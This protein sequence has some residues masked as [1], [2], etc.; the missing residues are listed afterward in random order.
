MRFF[1]GILN[2]K[3]KYKLALMVILPLMGLLYF[4]G[5]QLLEKYR[6]MDE[7]E[8]IQQLSRLAVKSSALVH[9]LQK[10][11]GATAGFL[12]SRGS[13][14]GQELKVQRENSNIR[15]QEFRVYLGS[16]DI[17]E[18]KLSDEFRQT[19]VMATEN[20]EQLDN[21]RQK[22]SALNIVPKDAIAYY[23]GINGLLLKSITFM[24]KLGERSDITVQSLA[25][26]NF[27]QGKERAGIERAVLSNTF[28]ADQFGPGMYKKFISLMSKQDAYADMYISL[29]TSSQRELY[30]NKMQGHAVEEV[31]RMRKIA[32]KNAT[33]GQF[34]IEPVYWFKTKTTRINLLKDVED[35]IAAE[36]EASAT[37]LSREAKSSLVESSTVALV[38][39]VV[40]IMIALMMLRSVLGQVNVLHDTM[41]DIE[42]NSDLTLRVDV[43]SSDEIGEM[44]ATFNLMM[45]KFRDIIHQVAGSI[46]QLTTSAEEMMA[47]TKQTDQGVNEQR[48]ETDQVA[49]AMTEMAATVQQVAQGAT[50]AAQAAQDADQEA[51]SGRQVVT[52]SMDSINILAQEVQN[53]ADVIQKLAADSEQIG[54]VLDVIKGIADQTNLLALNAAIEAA[55]AGE[56][57]RGFAVVADEVRTLAQRT[58]ESAGEIEGMIERLQSGAE[59]AVTVMENGRTQAVVS[60]EQAEKAVASL[61]AITKAVISIN[62][63]NTQI[64]SA[65]EQQTAVADEINGNIHNISQVAE[66]TSMST[67]E[68]KATGEHL[69]DLAVKL[70][71]TVDQFKV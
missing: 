50:S 70:R 26:V 71:A 17:S 53:A 1:Q 69:A 13:K 56:Q 9:E 12:G 49:T 6:Q 18:L 45:D 34:G 33:Q 59:K 68:T 20:L 60:V 5:M 46:H 58:Q 66:H 30:S 32:Q 16:L 39:A 24:S 36:L 22:V 15:L 4:S 62:D 3:V 51:G 61:E 43:K 23:T 67:N 10:E 11:R 25:Y 37:E 42:K 44:A 27:L 47:V 41:E 29:A 31:E 8:R 19:L 65:A 57:G 64:A 55:R 21:K 2:M 28:A 52:A 40:T 48:R 54:S 63:L 14:F 7:M 38:V 35:S